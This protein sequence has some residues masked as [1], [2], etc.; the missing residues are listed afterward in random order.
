VRA[1]LRAIVVP[2]HVAFGLLAAGSVDAVAALVW[3]LKAEPVSVAVACAG[4]AGIPLYIFSE[5][6]R[7]TVPR[8]SSLVAASATR[9][10]KRV[11]QREEELRIRHRARIQAVVNAGDGIRVVFQPIVDLRDGTR[12]GYEALARFADG[13]PP[14][15]WFTAAH[16]VGIGVELEMSAIARA[17]AEFGTTDGY[18]SIN[19]SPATLTSTPFLEF[20]TERVDPSRLVLELTEHSVIDD[21]EEVRSAFAMIRDL[22][23]RIAVDDAGSGTSSM[24]HI[25]K[26]APEIIKLDRSLIATID[27]DPARRA[28]ALS[29]AQF[30]TRIGSDLVAEGVE[31]SAEMT[32]CYESG[33]RYAQGYL[34]GRP[35]PITDRAA[36]RQ[37]L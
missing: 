13:R 19:L 22:G 4:V 20:L 17:V 14:N 34:L 8:D 36:S 32:A 2:R 26:L 7:R 31:R 35:G 9:P 30:A 12:V 6:R 10:T 1:H 28:L 21:Y 24:R 3:R 5:Y 25:L 15:E 11:R 16:N 27:S 37:D 29:L 33:I 18:L 23:A